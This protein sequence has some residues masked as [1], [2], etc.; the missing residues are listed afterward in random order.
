MK[1]GLVLEGGAM[2]GLFSAGV[3]DVLMENDIWP[4]GVIGVSAGA[5][6][7]CNMKSKQPG[8]VLRYNQKLAHDWRYASL[9]SL[10]T[11]GDYFGGEYA[12]HYMPRHIDY[13]DIDTFRENPMEFWAVCTNVG[14]GKAEYKRLTEVDDTCLEYIR[15]SA[16]MPIAARIVTVEGKKLLD[17]GIADSI[18]LRFFREQGYERN[19]VVL[20]QPEGYVKKQNS[21][22]R[23]MRMWLHRHPRIVRALEN[24]HIMYNEELAY[25]REEEKKPNTLVLRPKGKLTIGHISHDPAEMQA[26]YEQGRE[27]ALEKLEEIKALFEVK[28]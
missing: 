12:Y 9:R 27:V 10:L 19:L 24:R 8:R 7:G 13:F 4:D 25:I 14:T 26:T 21:F 23:L 11:T 20:T 2:R 28:G 5:A 6:F 16:S 3:M 22:M 17:G 18:P 1:K 15:A